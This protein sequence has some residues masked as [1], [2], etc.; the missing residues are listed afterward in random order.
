MLIKNGVGTMAS[1]VDKGKEVEVSNQG[2]KRLRK[3]TK[4]STS[5]AT[6]APNARRFGA[7]AM[8]PH[9]LKWFNAKKEAKYALRN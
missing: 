5:L 6:K 1:H 8:E 4:G 7:T 9:G 3:G 2:L